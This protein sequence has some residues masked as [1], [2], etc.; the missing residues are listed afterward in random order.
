MTKTV[1]LL[2]KSGTLNELSY[3]NC[4]LA[5]DDPKAE[6]NVS[7]ML[8]VTCARCR[9]AGRENLQRLAGIHIH[10][11]TTRL[12][13]ALRGEPGYRAGELQELLE[14]WKR[15]KDAQYIVQRIT[16]PDTLQEVRE[17]IC[18]DDPDV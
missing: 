6:H 7:N 4:G 3:T 13:A 10:R 18:D 9:A 5:F 15:V 8:Q 1:H 16:D 2:P 17:A 14:H 12:E 11:Y